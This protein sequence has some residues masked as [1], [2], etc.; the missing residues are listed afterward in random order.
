MQTGKLHQIPLQLMFF[1]ADPWQKM[2]HSKA[3]KQW[4]LRF[5]VTQSKWV[6]SMLPGPEA[7]GKGHWMWP[8]H[9][10]L[11]SKQLVVGYGTMDGSCISSWKRPVLL[12]CFDHVYSE[13]RFGS[14][15]MFFF[16][17]NLDFQGSKVIRINAEVCGL[18]FFSAQTSDSALQKSFPGNCLL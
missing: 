6:V 1:G 14:F 13:V 2:W 17:R 5:G 8:K 18:G 4:F 9:T 7:S 12:I 10:L 11:R 16:F 3:G 15:D